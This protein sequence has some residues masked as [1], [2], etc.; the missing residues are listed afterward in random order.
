[1]QLHMQSVTKAE[2]EKQQK[3]NEIERKRETEEKLKTDRRVKEDELK[4]KINLNAMTLA[5]QGM[6]TQ[7]Q[8]EK[9]TVRDMYEMKTKQRKDFETRVK[10]EEDEKK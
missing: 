8:A 7:H 10:A 3:L 6:I 5:N 4:K 2:L 1:M 9:R